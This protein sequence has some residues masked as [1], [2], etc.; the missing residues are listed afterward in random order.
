MD[1]MNGVA[2][3]MHAPPPF[4]PPPVPAPATNDLLLQLLE[5][6]TIKQKHLVCMMERSSAERPSTEKLSMAD[7]QLYNGQ[8]KTLDAFLARLKMN[9]GAKRQVYERPETGDHL[10]VLMALSWMREGSAEVWAVDTLD[11]LEKVRQETGRP[12]VSG[13]GFV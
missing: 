4:V 5:R 2:A 12:I 13:L 7:P 3:S 8:K 1:T 10:K 6:T 9:F 11:R